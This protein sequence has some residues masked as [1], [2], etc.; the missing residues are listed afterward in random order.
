MYGSQG[1]RGHVT[2]GDVVEEAEGGGA[3]AGAGGDA[4]WLLPHGAALPVAAAV[5]GRRHHLTLPV[6]QV[7][8]TLESI[9]GREGEEVISI[10]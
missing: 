10:R 1:S 8:W 3:A 4:A 6:L 9:P 5:S 2:H 7:H